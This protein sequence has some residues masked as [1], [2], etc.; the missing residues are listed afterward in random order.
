MAATPPVVFL[1]TL[2]AVEVADSRPLT[3]LAFARADTEDAAKAVATEDL[4]RLGW[5]DI[6]TVRT[7]ELVD[8]AALPDDFR[9][10]VDTAVRFGCG[11]IIYDEP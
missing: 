9:G 4:R 5:T 3:V 11:M 10:A 8:F 1:V 2:E 6:R 7:G